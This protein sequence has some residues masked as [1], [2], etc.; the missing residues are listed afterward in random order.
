MTT[1]P[2]ER[3]QDAVVVDALAEEDRGTVLGDPGA[4]SAVLEQCLAA[5]QLE[6]APHGQPSRSAQDAARDRRAADVVDLLAAVV[7]V[8]GRDRLDRSVTTAVL[9]A[10]VVALRQCARWC[11]LEPGTDEAVA[12]CGRACRVAEDAIRRALVD[13]DRVR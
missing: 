2:R 6:T 12:A 5:A 1:A 3:T 8:I 4:L 13:A 10:T 7:E 9:Q 11:E